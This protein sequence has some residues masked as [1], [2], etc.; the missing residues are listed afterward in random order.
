MR[1]PTSVTVLS[2]LNIVFGSLGLLFTLIAFAG[3]A[4]LSSVVGGGF[5]AWLVISSVIGLVLQV[6]LL[7]SGIAMLGLKPWARVMAIVAAV[8][9]VAMNLIGMIVNLTVFSAVPFMGAGAI[10]GAILGMAYPI[11]LLIFMFRPNVVAAFK[12]QGQMMPGM[13][14]GM[15]PMQPM[16]PQYPMQPQQPMP[17][18]YPMQ[19]QQPMQ[20]RPPMPPQPPRPPQR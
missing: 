15:Q 9:G 18:Q 8:G 12:M 11:V 20:P 10:I 3:I 6:L 14:G 2:V 7:T 5:V 16:P 13:P 4:E 1:R 17:P 19:P